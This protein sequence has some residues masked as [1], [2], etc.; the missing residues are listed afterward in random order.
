VWCLCVLE[1]ER[2]GGREKGREREREIDREKYLMEYK[3]PFPS[4]FPDLPLNI[5]MVRG[6]RGTIAGFSL[7]KKKKKSFK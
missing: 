7:K 2:E 4:S 5:W 1:R 6:G 3:L